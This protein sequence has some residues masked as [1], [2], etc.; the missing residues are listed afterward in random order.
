MKTSILVL[1]TLGVLASPALAGKDRPTTKKATPA[2]AAHKVDKGADKKATEITALKELDYGE[3]Y[4]LGGRR[5]ALPN[6][7]VETQEAKAVSDS[8]VGMVIRE[9]VEELE[10][11][12]LRVPAKKRVASSAMMNLAIEATGAVAG[13]SLDGELPRG[14]DRCIER[15]VMKWNFPAADKGC[16]VEHPLSF[17][18]K[19]DTVH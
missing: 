5:T 9:R 2:P 12:W 11:C 10:Y 4:V 8:Q 15:A 18:M 7:D 19:S 6:A 16:E 3:S 13:V 1:T 14:V 17:G